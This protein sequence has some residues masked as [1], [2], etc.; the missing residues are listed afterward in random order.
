[1]MHFVHLHAFDLNLLPV[2]QALL[3]TRSIKRAGA[4]VG[5]SPSATS[6]ALARLREFLGDPLLVRA[7][8]QMQLTARAETIAPRLQQALSMLEDSL[9]ETETFDP[10]TLDRSFRIATTDYVEMVLAP[11]LGT[12]LCAE[13][14]GVNLLH[15]R[16]RDPAAALRSGAVELSIHVAY[17][18]P[19][20]IESYP[21]IDETFACAM[22]SGHPALQRRLTARRFAALDHLLVSPRG[23]VRGIVDEKLEAMGLGRRVARTVASFT[24]A[25]FL[26]RDSDLVLTAPRRLVEA[27]AADLGLSIVPPPLD[28][29]GFTLALAWH[30]RHADDPAHAWLSTQ[31]ITAASQL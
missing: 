3:Q 15:E 23:G 6:H 29:T 21:L 16:T 17:P 1:M 18:M 2:L 24:A 9:E 12:R 27:V 4:L 26:L 8:R 25:P 7:G 30:R 31:V 22:R 10:L 20:D 28:L 19:D 13:G 14:P 5:L 11:A